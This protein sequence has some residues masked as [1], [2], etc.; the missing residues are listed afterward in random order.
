MSPLY[1]IGLTIAIT[2]GVAGGMLIEGFVKRTNGWQ[3]LLS[4]FEYRRQS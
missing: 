1:F 4:W 3:E 2:F